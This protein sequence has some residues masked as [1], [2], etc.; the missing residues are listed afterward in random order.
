MWMKI[1]GIIQASLLLCI[2]LLECDVNSQEVQMRSKKQ[3][4]VIAAHHKTGTAVCFQTLR[5][6]YKYVKPEIGILAREENVGDIAT[7]YH[8]PKSE[9]IIGL[10]WLSNAS[11]TPLKKLLSDN[12][13][14]FVHFVRDPVEMII[15]AYLYHL[16]KPEIEMWWLTFPGLTS[17]TDSL[18]RMLVD[19][20]CSKSEVMSWLEILEC[21]P[22]KE[23]LIAEAQKMIREVIY[24][25]CY[26]VIL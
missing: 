16:Q 15:S 26:V 2:I 11:T 3:K 17:S 9:H 12:S 13:I 10:D 14:K 23:G 18:E 22:E 25:F 1:G 6:L 20:G 24:L 5:P 8:G 21:L 4:M 19:H 7:L